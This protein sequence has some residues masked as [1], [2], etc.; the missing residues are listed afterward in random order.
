MHIRCYTMH[1]QLCMKDT[2]WSACIISTTQLIMYGR[3]CYVKFFCI[4]ETPDKNS[5]VNGPLHLRQAVIRRKL[6]TTFCIKSLRGE[7]PLA[8]CHFTSLTSHCKVKLHSFLTQNILPS[9]VLLQPKLFSFLSFS[10]PS[11]F[12]IRRKKSN[13]IFR[14]DPFTFFMQISYS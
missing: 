2:P 4:P 3:F 6:I 8:L 7:A 10:F 1:R 12:L 14:F 11:T 9:L 5:T 13:Q